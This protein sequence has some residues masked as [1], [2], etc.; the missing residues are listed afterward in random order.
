MNNVVVIAAEF[1]GQTEKLKKGQK[2]YEQRTVPEMCEEITV[3]IDATIEALEAGDTEAPMCK[4]VRHG[5][6][7][8]IGYGKNNECLE[9]IEPVNFWHEEGNPIGY[10]EKMRKMLVAGDFD[11]VL[12]A[13]RQELVE[14]ARKAR[15]GKEQKAQDTEQEQHLEAA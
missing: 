3:R 6:T 4:P 9:G 11:Q 14:R 1:G 13:K 15:E 10:L 7:I 8:K 2:P 12:E 5:V